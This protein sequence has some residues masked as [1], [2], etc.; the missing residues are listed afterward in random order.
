[1]AASGTLRRLA[2]FV[3]LWLA[4]VLAVTVVGLVI[5]LWLGT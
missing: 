1:M 4:G 3:G 2:W 5:K